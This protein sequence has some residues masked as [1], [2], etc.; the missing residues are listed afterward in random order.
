MRLVVAD[1]DKAEA[2]F[3]EAGV[4]AERHLGRLVIRPDLAY[5]ATLIFEG[6]KV[7]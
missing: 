4:K 3:T 5:G 6:A 2:V 7:G 1:I